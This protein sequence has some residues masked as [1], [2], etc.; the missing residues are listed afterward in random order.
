MD[1]DSAIPALGV[2]LLA[3]C[4]ALAGIV[5]PED[6]GGGME[7][8]GNEWHDP[9]FALLVHWHNETYALI[10]HNHDDVYALKVH[11]HNDTYA[12]LEHTHIESDITD[13]VHD[14][15]KIKSVPIDNSSIGAD[16]ILVYNGTYLVYQT[17]SGNST[18]DALAHR[19]WNLADESSWQRRYFLPRGQWTKVQTNPVFTKGA[20]GKF[21]D[22]MVA[23][24]C[25]LLINGIYK[26]WYSGYDG[27]TWRIGLAHSTDRVNWTRQNDGNA[28]FDVGAAGKFDDVHVSSPNVV[29]NG[30]MYHMWYRGYDGSN[31]RIGYAT[32][33][34]GVT[35]TRQNNGNAVLDLG[36]GGSWDETHVMIPIVYKLGK[37]Y[38]M[39]YVGYS[40]TSGKFR[41]GVAFCKSG[42]GINWQKYSGNPVI[43]E[44]SAGE[45]DDARVFFIGFYWDQGVFYVL[46]AGISN[47][48]NDYQIGIA[49]SPNGQVFTKYDA[50]PVFPASA[51]STDW[52]HWKESPCIV[53]VEDVF[54][55]WYGGAE[56]GG[57][58]DEIGLAKIP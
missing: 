11:W 29:Y 58:A 8:H 37:E 56:Q 39:C 34:D 1:G 33:S 52:D 13:L 14:A 43:Q 41:I 47:T 19:K 42:D 35:W 17:P 9:D 26:M 28:V 32:S 21:D 50:N 31:W 54:Y 27:S 10:G 22:T 18:T 24:P 36:A 4:L 7:Q 49:Y 25:V 6:A 15:E 2:G 44:G 3:L 23:D 12:L 5:L 55:M 51:T 48:G 20:T 16:K 38:W 57:S 30:S 40:A 45:W 53:R 46:Y